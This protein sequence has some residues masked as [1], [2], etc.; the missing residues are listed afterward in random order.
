MIFQSTHPVWGGTM[1]PTCQKH[2]M[3][4][5]STHPVWGGTRPGVLYPRR[6]AH[7]KTPTPGGV[8][9]HWASWRELMGEFQSTHPVWGGTVHG[10]IHVW[11]AVIS[12]HP[13]RV[14]WDLK[15]LGALRGTNI[16]IHPPRV[17]WDQGFCLLL[18]RFFYFNPPTPCGV[19]RGAS[20][21]SA[22]WGE[23]SIHPPRVGWDA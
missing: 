8:G 6:Q 21:L 16:S 19:G 7:L 5:Q 22:R 14:G 4:F 17:G 20:F 1:M 9:H 23:I 10:C 13:P 11:I 3:V 18:S 15:A 12:I 2:Y